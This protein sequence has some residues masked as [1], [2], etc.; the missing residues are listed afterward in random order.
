MDIKNERVL[1]SGGLSGFGRIFAR[2]PG[3]GESG[4]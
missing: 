4:S 3:V 2:T 1:I